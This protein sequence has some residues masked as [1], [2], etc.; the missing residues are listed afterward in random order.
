MVQDADGVV[1]DWSAY[2][3]RSHR[4]YVAPVD[5]VDP[6]LYLC[7]LD[8]YNQSESAR[9]RRRG[10]VE[11]PYVPPVWRGEGDTPTYARYPEWRQFREAA[12]D[13][14]KEEEK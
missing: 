4:N 7:W 11:M 12:V 13:A 8:A 3:V 1:E 14:F 5:L 6:I 2:P 10:P 9:G